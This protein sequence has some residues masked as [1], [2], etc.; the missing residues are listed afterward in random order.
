MAIAKANILTFV[1]DALNRSE[2]DIDT[3]I[4]AVLDELSDNNL[5]EAQDTDQSLSSSDTY[6]DEPSDF[7]DLIAIVLNDGTYDGEPLKRLS[8]IEYLRRMEDEAT[9][10][11]DEPEYYSHFN[12]KFYIYHPSDGD[13]T[14][15]IDYYK[16]HAQNVDSIEFG[17]EFTNCINFG[18]AYYVACKYRLSNYIAIWGPKYYHEIDVKRSD[19]EDIVTD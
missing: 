9:S 3:Q 10:D 13:Y 14:A 16:R 8:R 11:Y 7:K 4:Q 18:A 1:N 19:F 12:G 2:T 15:T 17:D 6:L 5:L